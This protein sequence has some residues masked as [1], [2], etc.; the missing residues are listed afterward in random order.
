MAAGRQVT[1]W[2]RTPGRAPDLDVHEAATIEEAVEASQLVV[3][4]VLNYEA[5]YAVLP[6]GSLTGRTVVQLTTGTPRQA[7]EM[8]TWAADHGVSYVDGGVMATPPLVGRPGSLV[9]YSGTKDAFLASEPV[10]TELG[11]A[12]FVGEDPGR[13][14]LYDL[15]LLSAMYGMFGGIDHALALGA[16]EHIPE[17]ELRPMIHDWLRGML[18]AVSA[19]LDPEVAYASLRMQAAN[20]GTLLAASREQGVRTDLVTPMGELLHRA[21]A[22]GPG[23]SLSDLLLEDRLHPDG[24][25]ADDGVTTVRS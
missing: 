18:G 1:V 2:N 20:Y 9:F 15:A 24:P 8:A 25:P 6:K 19:D 10:L 17:T 5:T 7:R 12:R 22:A 13:A 3:V 11:E 14:A 23:H 16:S 4:C 21:V